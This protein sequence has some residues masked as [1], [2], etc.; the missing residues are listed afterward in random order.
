[1]LYGP[2]FWDASDSEFSHTSVEEA[3]DAY[4]ANEIVHI[5]QGGVLREFFAVL[6]EWDDGS[7]QTEKF[8]TKEEA[9]SWLAQHMASLP[10]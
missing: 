7:L 1:M 4:G 5:W 8:A 9:Q 3:A 6:V 10:E 2:W